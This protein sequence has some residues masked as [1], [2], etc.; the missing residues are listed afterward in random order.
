[1]EGGSGDENKVLVK[2]VKVRFVVE[3]FDDFIK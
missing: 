1:M 3:S 2:V